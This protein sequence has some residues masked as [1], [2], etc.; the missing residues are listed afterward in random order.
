[1]EAGASHHGGQIPQLPSQAAWQQGTA[2]IR[3]IPAP[4][5]QHAE[6]RTNQKGL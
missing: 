3:E 5:R 2:F 4:A 6:S 1:M